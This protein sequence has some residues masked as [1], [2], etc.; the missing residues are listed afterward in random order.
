AS[1]SAE[2]WNQKNLPTDIERF[3]ETSGETTRMLRGL[4]SA[5]F[6]VARR[7]P[8]MVLMVAAT[9]AGAVGLTWYLS[10]RD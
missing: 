3:D 6:G 10:Q 5:A 9:I 1:E 7:R 2:T 4:P 8:G